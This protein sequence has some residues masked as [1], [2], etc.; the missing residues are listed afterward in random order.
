MKTYY[1]ELDSKNAGYNGN[2]IQI[3]Y[4]SILQRQFLTTLFPYPYDS[5]SF[6]ELSDV[7]F[8]KLKSILP[9][10]LSLKE[11]KLNDINM[12]DFISNYENLA[13]E[14]TL[15]DEKRESILS[16]IKPNEGN[17]NDSSFLFK[18]FS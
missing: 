14:L 1:L 6:F 10:G 13:N 18:K 9:I 15:I 12:N 2:T 11:V 5:T 7:D 17:K 4:K 8:L 3:P 16:T